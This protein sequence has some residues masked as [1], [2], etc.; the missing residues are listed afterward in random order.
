MV[1]EGVTLNVVRAARERVSVVAFPCHRKY[2]LCN[3]WTNISIKNKYAV[4][5]IDEISIS[6]HT[7]QKKNNATVIKNITVIFLKPLFFLITAQTE[8]I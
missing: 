5:L 1:A 3:N 7:A 2:Y 4:H 8:K 6:G